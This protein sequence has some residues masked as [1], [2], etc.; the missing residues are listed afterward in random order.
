MKI[1]QAI[2]S[3]PK[4]QVIR[5]NELIARTGGINDDVAQFL[6]DFS[7][8]PDELAWGQPDSI[9]FVAVNDET[10]SLSRSYIGRL[11]N[12]FNGSRQLITHHLVVERSQ[13]AAFENNP[14]LL[15]HVVRTAG[16]L[17]LDLES[18][19]ELNLLILENRPFTE[20]ARTCKLDT[21]NE[22]ERIAH[23]LKIHEQ[24]VFLGVERPLAFLCGLLA[25]F[26]TTDRLNLSFSTG[27]KV[28]DHRP[29]RLQFFLEKEKTLMNE[30]ASRQIR[31]ISRESMNVT[32]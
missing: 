24:V 6:C 7:P 5:H 31:T 28:C 27:L 3:S 20:I 17:T 15:A 4:S 14:A 9:N 23:A 1:Q 2:I 21:A 29:L 8:Q 11:D 30:L 18:D 10:F 16:G 26:A 32:V 12:H 22:T 19:G 25:N 13:M